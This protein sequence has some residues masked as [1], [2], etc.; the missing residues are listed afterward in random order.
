MSGNKY[1]SLKV[2]LLSDLMDKYIY[3]NE[4]ITE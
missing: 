3:V 2:Q 1:V 4:N